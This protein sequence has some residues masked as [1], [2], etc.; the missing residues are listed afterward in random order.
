MLSIG[1]RLRVDMQELVDIA[2]EMPKVSAIW[3]QD[4]NTKLVFE[5]NGL[6]IYVLTIQDLDGIVSQLTFY[7]SKTVCVHVG[8]YEIH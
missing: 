2:S 7:L 5:S 1:V 4:A 6:V 3:A 8:L